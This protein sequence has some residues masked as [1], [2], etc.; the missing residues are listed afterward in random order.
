[1]KLSLWLLIGAILFTAYTAYRMHR[2]GLRP[3]LTLRQLAAGLLGTLLLL[4]ALLLA[5]WVVTKHTPP[6][7][8]SVIEAQAMDMSA[9]HAPEGAAPVAVFTAH[10]APFNASVRYAANAVSYQEEAINP[11]V[12]GV[13]E[14][15][16]F[17]PNM[18]VHK[19]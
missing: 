10:Y 2:I 7:H 1:M 4:G 13:L 15:M 9:M 19:G 14:W 16:P 18:P 8:M 3:H 5:R 11:R 12:T 17:Y 6:G